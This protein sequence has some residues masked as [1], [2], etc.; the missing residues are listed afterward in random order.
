MGRKLCLVDDYRECA[1]NALLILGH[2]CTDDARPKKPG[3]MH[4]ARWMACNL[5]AAKMLMYSEQMHYDSVTVDKLQRLNIFLQ[6]F[7]V[8]LWLNAT[9]HNKKLLNKYIFNCSYCK[10]VKKR[11]TSRIVR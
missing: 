11:Q 2:T 4:H 9:R 10:T 7:Y 6:L 1:E 8:P 5:Y 3:A